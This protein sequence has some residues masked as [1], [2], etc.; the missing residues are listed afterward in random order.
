MSRATAEQRS[1][2]VALMVA[3]DFDATIITAQP[4]RLLRMADCFLYR[5]VDEWLDSLTVESASALIDK[6]QRE[7]A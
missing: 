6:L 2:L 5:P 3:R 4:W 7:V 1:Q